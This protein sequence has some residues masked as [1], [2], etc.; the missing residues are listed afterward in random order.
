[1]SMQQML[2][3]MAGAGADSYWYGI[4]SWG[5]QSGSLAKNHYQFSGV[6]N[7]PN[8]NIFVSGE[9][10]YNHQYYANTLYA[11]I[12]SDGALQ[13]QKVY[14]YST[15]NSSDGGGVLYQ[16]YSNPYISS[17]AEQECV[18]GQ[19]R[20]SG[21]DAYFTMNASTLE[22]QAQDSIQVYNKEYSW[23]TFCGPP[24][25]FKYDNGWFYQNN[26]CPSIYRTGRDGYIGTIRFNNNCS[27]KSSN[28]GVASRDVT[29]NSGGNTNSPGV[30]QGPTYSNAHAGNQYGNNAWASKRMRPY[31]SSSGGIWLT[32]Y[33]KG[34]DY[35]DDG[36]MD[37]G[38]SG[39]DYDNTSPDL[40][41]SG[42]ATWYDGMGARIYI[43]KLGGRSSMSVRFAKYISSHYSSG[44]QA[45]GQSR[46]DSSYAYHAWR[47]YGPNSTSVGGITK[48][49]HNGN[50]QWTKVLVDK[51]TQSSHEFNFDHVA[52]QG[53]E[54]DDDGNSYVVGYARATSTRTVG[55]IAKI[56]AN[57]TMGWQNIFYK[58]SSNTNAYT[59]FKFVR[60][61][62]M[63]SLVIVGFTREDTFSGYNN[64][65]TD[66]QYDKGIVLKVASDGSG[67]GTY[68]DYTYS[69]STFALI[70]HARSW[71]NITLGGGYN[72]QNPSRGWVEQYEQSASDTIST[73]SM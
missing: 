58:T 53:I 25:G 9:R 10:S 67:T 7:D 13:V 30:Y 15:S 56:N 39:T 8:D 48:F 37:G 34:I 31:N 26:T 43:A 64:T 23:S 18:W 19:T 65:G 32:S 40:V 73:T 54:I 52:F 51:S 5:S 59:Q 4:Y 38:G 68:G 60:K 69:T 6:S 47:D 46:A 2:I 55:V 16:R 36:D 1:M 3:A 12:D 22:P 61:N 17:G 66:A 35:V 71:S 70:S 21:S 20:M 45:A 41:L 27:N 63:D 11:K 44:G 57:G 50:E 42:H 62:S 33:H 72:Y 24:T 28:N 14:R 29:P 49:D